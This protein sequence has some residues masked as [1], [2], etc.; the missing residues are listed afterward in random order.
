VDRRSDH[1]NH[2]PYEASDEDAV[3]TY[4]YVEVHEDDIQVA[5]VTKMKLEVYSFCLSI[6]D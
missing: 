5:V 3:H 4:S 2:M 1:N 6:E